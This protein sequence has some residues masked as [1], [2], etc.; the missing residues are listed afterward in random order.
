MTE[1]EKDLMYRYAITVEQKSA[2]YYKS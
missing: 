1:E 2:Y